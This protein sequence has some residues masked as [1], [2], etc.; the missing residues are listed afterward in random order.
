MRAELERELEALNAE[1]RHYP[2]PIARCDEQLAGLIERRARLLGRLQRM[3][4]VEAA[5]PACTWSN[6]GG[7]DAA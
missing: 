3:E 2:T 6:D 4:E 1:L 7:F 5:R